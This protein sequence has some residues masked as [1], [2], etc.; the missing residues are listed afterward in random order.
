MSGNICPKC[1]KPTVSGLC[2]DCG[3]TDSCSAAENERGNKSS[4][5][6][7]DLKD[8]ELP[9]LS[10]ISGEETEIPVPADDSETKGTRQTNPYMGV[11]PFE[12]NDFGDNYHTPYGRKKTELSR[13]NP[14]KENWYDYWYIILIGLI[15]PLPLTIGI[16]A[17]LRCFDEKSGRIAG[18][19]TAV[20]AVLKWLIF[21]KK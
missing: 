5:A 17:A 19:I 6:C 20:L 8:I 2:I 14:H 7:R 15:L 18:V 1:G 16:A 3:M 9:Q 4:A 21:Y 12:Q 10:T 11:V 13:F